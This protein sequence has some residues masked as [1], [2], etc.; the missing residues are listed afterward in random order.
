MAT[1]DTQL[2]QLVINV[3]TQAQIDAAIQGGTITSDMLSVVTDG[4][5]YVTSAD[6]ATV[7]TSGSYNDLSNKPT[8]PTVNNATLTI[9]QG[10]VTKGTFTANAGTDVTIALDA[11]GG[12]GDIDCGT[13]S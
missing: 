2:Q 4:P 7:A 6:L 3:G 11:G 1:T 9:T 10:G 13:M 12:G 8:I 5:S